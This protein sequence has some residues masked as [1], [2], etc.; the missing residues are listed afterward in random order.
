MYGLTMVEY[1]EITH[2]QSYRMGRKSQCNTYSMTAQLFKNVGCN[3]GWPMKISRLNIL[4]L[5]RIRRYA[6]I[7]RFQ[8]CF[9]EFLTVIVKHPCALSEAI[10]FSSYFNLDNYPN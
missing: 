1:I 3:T 8:L 6:T 2:G 9:R 5:K 10:N 4:Q 7:K